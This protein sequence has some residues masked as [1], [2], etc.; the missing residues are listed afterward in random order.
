MSLGRVWKRGFFRRLSRRCTIVRCFEDCTKYLSHQVCLLDRSL[1]LPPIQHRAFR[2]VVQHNPHSVELLRVAH[3]CG[4]QHSTKQR[5]AAEQH[6]V[7]GVM[8]H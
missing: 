3:I 7:G 2:G 8:L 6:A 1:V 4:R 5:A